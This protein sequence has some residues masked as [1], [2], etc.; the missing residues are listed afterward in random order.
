MTVAIGGITVDKRT[1]MPTWDQGGATYHINLTSETFHVTKEGVPK[2]HYFFAADGGDVED[3]VPSAA[4]RG[5]SKVKV[6]KEVVYTKNKFSD[7]PSAVQQYIRAN[8][9]ALIK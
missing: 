7:L 1:N 3:V 9:L 6:G 8:Y 4:E 2:V 5:R